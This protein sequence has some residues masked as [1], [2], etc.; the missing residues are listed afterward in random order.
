MSTE[1]ITRVSVFT[2]RSLVGCKDKANV[3]G[4]RRKLELLNFIIGINFL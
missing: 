4:F 3:S 2:L 1:Q